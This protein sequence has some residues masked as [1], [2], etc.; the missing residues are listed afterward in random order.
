MDSKETVTTEAPE[1]QL[2]QSEMI[3]GIRIQASAMARKASL[4]SEKV[5]KG[6]QVDWIFDKLNL[7]KYR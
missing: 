4:A 6:L 3:R 7:V 1:E 2:T 5:L